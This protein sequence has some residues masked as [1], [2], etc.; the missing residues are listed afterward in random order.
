MGPHLP[1]GP[2][3]ASRQRFSPRKREPTSHGHTQVHVSTQNA[4][5]TGLE[6]RSFARYSGSAIS[7]ETEPVWGYILYRFWPILRYFYT[8]YGLTSRIARG[9][10]STNC[11]APHF[12]RKSLPF[13]APKPALPTCRWWHRMLKRDGSLRTSKTDLEIV[14]TSTN[15]KNP[16]SALSRSGVTS[17]LDEQSLDYS[18][19]ATSCTT[20]LPHKSL[21][22]T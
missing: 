22:L 12:G 6:T 19:I 1:H 13:V 17:D 5:P 20:V 3:A 21:S 14:R 2:K 16:R 9:N 15:S 8:L 10:P 18:T 4:N 11:R 7:F